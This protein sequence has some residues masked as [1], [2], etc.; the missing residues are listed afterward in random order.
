MPTFD[1]L[2]DQVAFSLVCKDQDHFPYSLKLEQAE[3]DQRFIHS[4]V[5]T[6]SRDWDGCGGRTDLHEVFAAL[7]AAVL[8]ANGVASA[9]LV[10]LAGWCPGEVHSRAL[11]FRQPFDALSGP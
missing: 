9:E 3:G 6:T 10:D 7:W 5:R 2:A 11:I 1:A 4:W 8:R